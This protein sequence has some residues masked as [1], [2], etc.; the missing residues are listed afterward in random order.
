M[1]V[2][3]DNDISTWG[4]VRASGFTAAEEMEL[5]SRIID[6]VNPLVEQAEMIEH[7]DYVRNMF[8][9]SPYGTMTFV[10]ASLRTLVYVISEGVSDDDVM[11]AIFS[12]W[13]STS[14]RMQDFFDHLEDNSEAIQKLIDEDNDKNATES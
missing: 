13:R 3:D 2:H 1:H 7:V 6:S 12:S 8:E 10:L 14:A 9:K 4:D 11:R 5:T